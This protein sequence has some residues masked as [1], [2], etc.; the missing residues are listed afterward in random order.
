MTANPSPPQPSADGGF[1]EAFLPRLLANGLAMVGIAAA[2]LWIVRDQQA[3]EQ[4]RFDLLHREV[5]DLRQER[6]RLAALTDVLAQDAH[7][8]SIEAD[9]LR[10]QLR[11]TEAEREAL[12]PLAR[13]PRGGS[14]V[15]AVAA[16]EPPPLP[17]VPAPL[18]LGAGSAMLAPPVAA[19]LAGEGRAGLDLSDFD[20]GIPRLRPDQRALSRAIASQAWREVLSEAAEGECDGLLGANPRCEDD[21]RRRLWPYGAAAIQ[22]MASGNAVPDYIAEIQ[23]ENLPTHSVP[24]KRGAIILCDGA[25]ANP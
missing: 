23:I 8:S 24:L 6:D 1:W 4:R 5:R 14:P 13:R 25:L 18:E 22:C 20:P 7:D 2:V 10:A 9:I 12:R 17:D 3:V 21:V 15:V 19:S 11:H 16:V